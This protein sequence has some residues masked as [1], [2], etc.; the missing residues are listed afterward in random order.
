MLR[1]ES[2][3][4]AYITKR[5]WLEAGRNFGRK[6]ERQFESELLA[7]TQRLKAK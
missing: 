1:I 7:S 6:A 3:Q 5:I 2:S 4:Y